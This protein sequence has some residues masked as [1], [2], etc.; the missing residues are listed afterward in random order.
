MKKRLFA[1]FLALATLL[2][3][4]FA[5]CGTASN[6]NGEVIA[7]DE[8]AARKPKTVVLTLMTGDETTEEAIRAVQDEINSI[9]TQRFKTQVILRYFKES[10]YEEKID[11]IVADIA[12]EQTLK[13]ELES[14]ADASEKESKRHS[15]IDKLIAAD[16]DEGG[17]KSKWYKE[18]VQEEEES[19]TEFYETEFN[20]LGASV[21]KYPT[22]TST[23][24]DIFLICGAENLTKYVNDEAYASDGESFL[25]QLDEMLAGTACELHHY[26]NPNALAAGKVGN[27]TYAIPTNRQLASEYTYLVLDKELVSKY[28]IDE[29]KI[30]GLTDKETVKFLNAVSAG[31]ADVSPILNPLA[32]IYDKADDD[33]FIEPISLADAP[34][35]VGLFSGETTMFGTY[36]S[37][38]STTGMKSVPKNILNQWQYTEFYAY[39]KQFERNGY[40]CENPTG[41]TKYALKVVSGDEAFASTVDSNKYI[42]KILEKPVAS[43]E[44]VGEYM[45]GISKYAE[46]ADRCMEIITFLNTNS[47]FRNLLQYG[48]PGVN[49]K[50]EEDTGKLVRLNR[51]YMMNIY[52]TGNTFIAHPEEDMPLDVWEKAKE[53]NKSTL[54]SPYLGFVFENENNAEL[55]KAAKQLSDEMFQRVNDYDP[56]AERV[57]KINACNQVI[58]DAEAALTTLRAENVALVAAYEP[59]RVVIDPIQKQY[60][61]IKARL[62]AANEAN[63]PFKDEVSKLQAEVDKQ[64]SIITTKTADIEAT[65][66]KIDDINASETP[67]LEQLDFQQKNLK[68]MQEALADAEKKLADAQPK[69]DAAKVAME[70][71]QAV[72]DSITAEITPVEEKLEAEKAKAVEAKTA[73]DENEAQ[74]T[75]NE[76]LIAANQKLVDSMNIEGVTTEELDQIYFDLYESFFSQLNAELRKNETYVAFMS[77]DAE[78]GIVYI[79][80]DWY[81]SMYS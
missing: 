63:K 8:I 37:N 53:T 30:T 80:N 9:T 77:A 15:A 1:L 25:L 46:N 48:I 73:L 16:K 44:T 59:F 58:A 55:I 76:E 71:T 21:E 54:V 7:E 70:P 3:L 6:Q 27:G 32:G 10:E 2:P 41:D 43:T 68:I 28:G 49:Y 23:Q 11:Q 13:A 72:V 14:K 24:M 36:L 69:L 52:V 65:Q 62:D 57:A 79:Y 47:E 56:E 12:E 66:K 31:E 29:S 60:D 19:E 20:I 64:T 78:T 18:E 34:G 35:I 33:A 67:D 75:A 17:R 42:V 22:A 5:S 74:I 40:F 26:L 81:D 51:D 50:I 45:L 39:M 61:G 38:A 4:V